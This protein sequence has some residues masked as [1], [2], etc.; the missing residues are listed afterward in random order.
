MAAIPQDQ[1][2]IE[3]LYTQ[4]G[5]DFNK[6]SN[7]F[8]KDMLANYSIIDDEYLKKIK[9]YRHRIYNDW[10]ND[11]S[12]EIT[13]S[14]GGSFDRIVNANLIL[15]DKNMTATK[16]FLYRLNTPLP[17]NACIMCWGTGSTLADFTSQMEKDFDGDYES[18]TDALQEAIYEW[19]DVWPNIKDKSYDFVSAAALKDGVV[20]P[21]YYEDVC[22]ICDG[23]G[24]LSEEEAKIWHNLVD[25]IAEDKILFLVEKLHR[26][27]DDHN[28][29]HRNN[30][31]ER[32]AG[33]QHFTQVLE[34]LFK[35]KKGDT[36][37]AINPK[38]PYIEGSTLLETVNSIKSCIKTKD[39]ES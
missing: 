38:V 14:Q 22:P 2:L 3:K 27:I 34:N 24:I 23:E 8:A 10:A 29:I 35:G 7:S 6:N 13:S 37:F 18:D 39:V 16:D 19:I 4:Q 12:F 28:Q 31:S 1:K 25:E 26:M 11:Y 20:Y 21:S 30:Y 15:Q 17:E 33:E 36:N 5:F 9:N 32:H